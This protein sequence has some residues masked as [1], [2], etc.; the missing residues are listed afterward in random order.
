MFAATAIR[1]F[2]TRRGRAL[3][4]N[5][6]G[7]GSATLGNLGR[8]FTE[9]ECDRTLAHAWDRGLR[10]FDTA[11]LYGLGLSE[12]R[13]GR[14]LRSRPRDEYLLS[15]KVGRLIEPCA[16]GESNA[17]VF[18]TA[19]DRKFLYDYSYDGVMRSFE[20][21][22]KRLGLD[23]IDILLVHDVDGFTHGSREA[24]E[25]RIQELMR[26]G[27]WRAL[28]E[29][30]ANGAV[31]AIGL[32]VNEGQPCARILELADP[33]LFLLA[34][35]YTLLEQ[36]PLGTLFPQCAR[37][38][39]GIVIGGPYN[40]GV[41][42]GKPTFDYASIPPDVAARVKAL[43][44]ICRAHDVALRAAALQFVAAH[45][46]VVSVIPGAVSPEEVDDNVAMLE[47]AIPPALW[48]D[49]KAAGLLHPDAPTP[50]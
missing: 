19:P 43:T 38:G 44:E 30:R 39:A 37:A 15:T 36:A 47:A 9:E 14:N 31:S 5:L 2:V 34:G 40:S 11:P 7:F 41:L 29:L 49:L 4:F 8:A 25:A 1:N 45:P 33:D 3:P 35:R 23:R 16:P 46:L 32:G 10:Y 13:V 24:S 12:E 27:G 6:L 28:D 20:E 42:A 48:R 26:T 50:A 21:S 22:L 18:V 17:G